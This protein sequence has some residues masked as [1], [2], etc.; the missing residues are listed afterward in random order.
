MVKIALSSFFTGLFTF[1]LTQRPSIIPCLANPDVKLVLDKVVAAGG[2]ILVPKMEISPDYGYLGVF[3]DTEGNRI[4]L[5]S[6]P[7]S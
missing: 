3:I 5:H 1:G 2:K 4:A 6:V 7:Q